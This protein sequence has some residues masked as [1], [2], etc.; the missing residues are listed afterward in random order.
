VLTGPIRSAIAIVADRKLDE[1]VIPATW[2]TP[3][4]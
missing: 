1:L 3:A 2:V 4:R